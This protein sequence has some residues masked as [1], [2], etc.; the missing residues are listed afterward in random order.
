MIFKATILNYV[1]L[2]Y[3]EMSVTGAVHIVTCLQRATHKQVLS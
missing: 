2:I 3:T 1:K